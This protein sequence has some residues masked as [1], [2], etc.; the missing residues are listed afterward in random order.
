MTGIKHT[1]A[2]ESTYDSANSHAFNVQPP[3]AP[4]TFESLLH[5]CMYIYTCIHV[6][7]FV[8]MVIRSHYS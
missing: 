2:F 5:L 3:S 4:P 1:V 6:H 8:L 7:V